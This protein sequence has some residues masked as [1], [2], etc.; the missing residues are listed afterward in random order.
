V[1]GRCARF[2]PSALRWLFLNAV[3]FGGGT[4]SFKTPERSVRHKVA[5]A[6]RQRFCGVRWEENRRQ[7]A[8]ATSAF[9]NQ[10]NYISPAGFAAKIRPDPS[11]DNG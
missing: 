11:L 10:K 8:G 5:P 3:R 7:D 6:S 9:V 4:Y 1:N 2:A